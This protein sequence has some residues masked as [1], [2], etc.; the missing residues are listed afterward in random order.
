[1]EK[2]MRKDMKEVTPKQS[3]KDVEKKLDLSL[4]RIEPGKT[5]LFLQK[6][7][8]LK[9]EER[10][11]NW[12]ELITVGLNLGLGEEG[13]WAHGCTKGDPMPPGS[14]QFEKS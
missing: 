13:P 9:S 6:N 11:K 12:S 4:C 10:A 8:S 7:R 14:K 1:M 3:L 2:S 5:V